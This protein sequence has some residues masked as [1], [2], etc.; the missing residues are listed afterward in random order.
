MPDREQKSM[1][2]CFLWSGLGVILVYASAVFFGVG[3]RVLVILPA[4]V[5]VVKQIEVEEVINFDTPGTVETVFNE[6]PHMIISQFPFAGHDFEVVSV[7]SS[8]WVPVEKETREIKY[9]LEQLEGYLIYHFDVPQDGRYRIS[10][11]AVKDNTVQISPNY[12]VRN[13]IAIA[14]FYGSLVGGILLFVWL[15][16]RPKIKAEIAERKTSAQTK[17]AKWDALTNSP[18]NGQ[19]E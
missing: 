14:L 19:N 5:G 18:E 10:E 7:D 8:Q 16:R 15:W 4:W 9:E 13:Q 6:G 17:A 1:V 12:S 2:G 3:A 11:E